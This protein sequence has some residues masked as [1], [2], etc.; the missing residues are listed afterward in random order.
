MAE[1]APTQTTAPRS[2]DVIVALGYGLACHTLFVAGVG[3][4]MVAMFFGMS[5]SLGTLRLPW[6]ALANGLLL[7]QFPVLHSALLSRPGRA[8]LSRLAPFRLGG[9]LS[10][11]TYAAIASAQVGALFLLWSPSGIVWWSAQGTTLAVI[12]GFYAAAWL[13]LLKSIVD[14]GMAMQVGSLGWWAVARGVAPVYP[15]MP[16]TGLFRLCRQ[17][18]YVAFALTLWTVPTLTP[19]QLVVSSVLTLYC[20]IGPLFKEARFRRLFGETFV[21]YQ[22]AVPYWFP[23]PRRVPATPPRRNDLT[24]YDVDASGWWDGTVRWRRQLRKLVPAR[25]AYLDRLVPDWQKR[26][27]LDLGCGG[28]YMAEALAE[29]GAHVV[30]V[31]PSGA[32]IAAARDHAQAG[33]LL[34][35]Y[36]VGVGEAIPVESRMMDIVVCVDVLEHVVDLDAVLAEVGRVLRPGGLF[37]FDTI[38]RTRLAVFVIVTLGESMLRLLPRGTHDP[39]KFIRPTDL[40]ARLKAHGFTPSRMVGFGPRGLDRQGDFRFGPL[41]T[42]SIMYLGHA[43]AAPAGP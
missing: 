8:M 16:R 28:G 11:T 3:T 27:I 7:L 2:R 15:P 12:S 18:I 20:L 1:L 42:A 17:P 34:I 10:T 9:R 26:R 14:A 4:M 39:A 13:L 38:N 32:A 29:R 21:A 33:G 19:D 23:W 30:G 31:D 37:V 6:S 41:P 24:I 40:R 25:M 36:R 43:H 22:Q 35:D 5:R